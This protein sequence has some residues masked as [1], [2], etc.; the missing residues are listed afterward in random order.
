MKHED[1]QK[2]IAQL[3]D[4]GYEATLYEG[5]SG[6]CMY[7]KTTYGVTTD[8]RPVTMELHGID[9]PRMDGMGLYYIYY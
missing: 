4:A 5:Y 2:M 7:G 8:C 6:R 1:A 9:Y 3:E